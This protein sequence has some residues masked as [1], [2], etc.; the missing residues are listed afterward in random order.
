MES[1]NR[2]VVAK[3]CRKGMNRQRTG[4]MGQWKYSVWYHPDGY[5]SLYFRADSQNIQLQEWILTLIMDVKWPTCVNVGS[6]KGTNM[7]PW[8]WTLIRSICVCVVRDG[9]YGKS[10]FRP[11]TM[12]LNVLCEKLSQLKIKSLKK[13]KNTNFIFWGTWPAQLGE[14]STLASSW[15]HEFEPHVGCRDYFT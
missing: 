5:L 4:I 14:H 11:L 13:K 10:L 3:E 1:V 12:K 2:S 6:P 7:P 8:Q 9:A 15:G